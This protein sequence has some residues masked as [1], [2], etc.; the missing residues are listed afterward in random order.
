MTLHTDGSPPASARRVEIHVA[1]ARPVPEPRQGLG[2]PS[3]LWAGL[4]ATLAVMASGVYITRSPLV[5]IF[6]GMFFAGLCWALALLVNLASPARSQRAPV[7]AALVMLPIAG[8]M[9]LRAKSQWAQYDAD[10]EALAAHSGPKFVEKLV[11]NAPFLY[12]ISAMHATRQCADDAYAYGQFVAAQYELEKG[13]G[14][15]DW[16]T[17]DYLT[18]PSQYPR[19]AEWFTNLGHASA[20]MRRSFADYFVERG[21][22]HFR[23]TGIPAPVVKEIIRGMRVALRTPDADRPFD[24]MDRFAAT[25][26]ALDNFLRSEEGGTRENW[27]SGVRLRDG[28][29]AA[30]VNRRIEALKAAQ[31]D[32]AV[33]GAP[34]Q[35]PAPAAATP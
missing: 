14:V 29:V 24:A 3:S 33:Y 32:L 19:V 17:E 18:H 20:A 34:G 31:Q 15:P 30:E 11:G 10:L 1:P 13:F 21:E 6:G 16:P 4:P 5:G 35:Q 26:L 27:W 23:E 22:V 8:L 12:R 7:M 2:I 25:G 28:R 9:C